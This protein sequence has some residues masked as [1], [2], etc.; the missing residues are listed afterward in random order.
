M[1]ATDTQNTDL[2][3]NSTSFLVQ[4][5]NANITVQRSPMSHNGRINLHEQFSETFYITIFALSLCSRLFLQS[6]NEKWF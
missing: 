3:D 2:S 6:H 5:K 4:C 1:G